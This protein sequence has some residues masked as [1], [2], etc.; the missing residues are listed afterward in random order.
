MRQI[1]R[2]QETVLHPGNNFHE[3][4]TIHNTA[5]PPFGHTSLNVLTKVHE[6]LTLNV[7]ST[8]LNIDQDIIGTNMW[9][10]VHEDLTTSAVYRVLTRQNVEDRRKTRHHVRQTKCVPKSSPRAHCAQR[11]FAR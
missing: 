7:T 1:K 2:E 11:R 4:W 10:I 8:V 5:P 3:D 6:D 9:A